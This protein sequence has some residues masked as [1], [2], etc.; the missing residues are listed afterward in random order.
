MAASLL[1]AVVELA[2]VEAGEFAATVRRAAEGSDGAGAPARVVIVLFDQ[3]VPAYADAYDMPNFRRLRDAG[4]SFERAYLGYMASETV[5][6]R[7][8]DWTSMRPSAGPWTSMV[9]PAP[10]R[11]GPT[12]ARPSIFRR[13]ARRAGRHGA[14]RRGAPRPRGTTK[15]AAGVCRVRH[16]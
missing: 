10:W 7:A 3:M 1:E 12:L 16:G 9:W 2:V 14:C 5:M 8:I 15:Q 4:T 11:S 13:G 6:P